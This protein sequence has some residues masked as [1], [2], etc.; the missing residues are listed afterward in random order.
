MVVIVMS[1]N[2]MSSEA[3]ARWWDVTLYHISGYTD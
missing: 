2:G 1:I 3:A